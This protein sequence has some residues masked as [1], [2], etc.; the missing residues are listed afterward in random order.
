MKFKVNNKIDAGG[1]HLQ[2]YFSCS[3]AESD[4]YKVSTEWVFTSGSKVFTLYDYK[5]TC[6]Y[7]GDYPTV[8]E[9]R[10]KPSHKW[11]VGGREKPDEFIKF[12]TQA[13]GK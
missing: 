1:T 5:E 4:G 11:H 2:G 13:V 6:L 10:E 7:D 12:L 3:Y 8:E 9:F